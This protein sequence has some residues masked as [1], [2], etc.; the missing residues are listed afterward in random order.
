M[1]VWCAD[2]LVLY[3]SNTKELITDFR[4]RTSDLQLI[5]IKGECAA[6][7]PSCYFLCVHMDADFQCMFLLCGLPWPSLDSP[8][9]P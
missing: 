5:C 7:A 2:I 9:C 1:E 3:T 6:R 8:V 4:R